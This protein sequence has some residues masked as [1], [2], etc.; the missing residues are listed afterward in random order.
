MAAQI[1]PPRATPNTVN[2]MS[3]WTSG[4]SRPGET[5]Q[6]ATKHTKLLIKMGL[7]DWISFSAPYLPKQRRSSLDHRCMVV[8]GSGIS[9]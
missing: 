8:G 2:R 7:G 5:P 3:K 9:P 4:R 1:S 6:R